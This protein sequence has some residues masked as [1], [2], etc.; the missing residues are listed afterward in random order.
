VED[1]VLVLRS[2][3]PSVHDKRTRAWGK[4]LGSVLARGPWRTG[5]YDRTGLIGAVRRMARKEPDDH[6]AYGHLRA[7]PTP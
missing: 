2:R 4:A 5:R 6:Q 3:F 7:S 1:F